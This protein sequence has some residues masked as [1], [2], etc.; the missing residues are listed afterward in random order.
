MTGVS[1]RRSQAPYSFYGKLLLG[2][3]RAWFARAGKLDARPRRKRTWLQLSNH[4]RR[5]VGLAPVEP[6]PDVRLWWL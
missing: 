5:D 2:E 6:R 4:L 1:L 3:L